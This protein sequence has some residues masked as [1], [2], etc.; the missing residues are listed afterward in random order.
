L[1]RLKSNKSPGPDEFLPKLL[2]EAGNEVL[3]NLVK[4]SNES[5]NS[6]TVPIDWK[7]ANVT[8]I[9]KKKGCKE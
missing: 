4:L 8:P 5:L 7:L 3:E 1:Q 9:Y 6:C 2:I